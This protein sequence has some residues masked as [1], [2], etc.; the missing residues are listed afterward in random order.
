MQPPLPAAAS[1]AAAILYVDDGSACDFAY[2]PGTAAQSLKSCVWAQQQ[3]MWH[4]L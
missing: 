3:S 2:L 1:A 4:V